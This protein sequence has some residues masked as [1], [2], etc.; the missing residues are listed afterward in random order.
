[1][2]KTLVVPAGGPPPGKALTTKTRTKAVMMIFITK[3]ASVW[4]HKLLVHFQISGE[5]LGNYELSGTSSEIFPQL[6]STTVYLRVIFPDLEPKS[7]F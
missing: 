4:L 7:G 6:C 5:P 2:L 1:M 3:R